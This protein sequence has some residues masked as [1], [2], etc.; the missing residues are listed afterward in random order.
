MLIIEF[1]HFQMKRF[2]FWCAHE[3]VDFRIP[4]FETLASLFNIDLRWVEKSSGKGEERDPWVILD[5]ESEDDAKKII[6]RSMSTR[7]CI[8][9]WSSSDSR[10]GMHEGIKRYIRE[11]PE[12]LSK[13]MKKDFKVHVEAFMKKYNTEEKMWRIEAFQ[14]VPFEGNVKLDNPEVTFTSLEFFGFDHNNLPK[15][16]YRLFFGRIVGEGQRQLIKK[17]SLKTRIFIGNTS[18]DPQ[19]SFLMSNMGR[20]KEGDLVLDPFCGTGGVL[21][22]SAQFG[23][24][25]VGNDI[26]Y[27][28]IHARS[29]PSR[30]SQK[31]R[32]KGE[33]M[34]GNFKQYDLEKRY[35]GVMVADNSRPFYKSSLGQ[36]FQAIITDPP[37]GLREPTEK[38]GTTADK[39]ERIPEEF[40]EQ[41]FPKKVTS[42]LL[43]SCF[44]KGS[45]PS[46]VESLNFFRSCIR[47][48][49]STS[50]C[51]ILPGGI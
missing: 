35:L 28:T 7:Y 9:L 1:F 34:V 30:V 40:L 22:T 17:F 4:E 38:V 43:C 29:R 33:N 26:D 25:V 51:S 16:P 10:D 41:H 47:L 42:S 37:Y 8:E 48:Q 45:N 3:H 44:S 23:A 20:I 21:L 31:K 32:L 11:N 12:S 49:I 14:Y 27:M 39:D 5:L 46:K 24:Y 18:M 36:M 6:S 13:W 15:E 2:L 50:I 19:L